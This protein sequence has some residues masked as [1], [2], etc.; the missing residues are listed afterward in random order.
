MATVRVF[1][2]ARTLG[3]Q[4]QAL[5]EALEQMGAGTVT[6]ASAIDEQTAQTVVDLL[7]E[8]AK[9]ARV[10]RE[11]AEAAKEVEAAKQPEAAKVEEGEAAE[12]GAAEAEKEAAEDVEA[13]QRRLRQ[14]RMEPVE[15]VSQL[16]RHIRELELVEASQRLAPEQLGMG[17]EAR[18][19][20][21][22]RPV[23]AV[24]AA[25]VVTVLGHVDHGKTT[26]LD[27]IRNTQVAAGESGGIT[28]H[29][30]ASEVEHQGRRIVFI[31]TPGHAAFT[32][33]RA[34]GAQVTDIAVLVVAATEG[35]RP[36]TIEAV[37]HA[38]AAGVPILVAVN[39]IDLPGADPLRTRQQ[40]LEHGLVP[41]EWG[42]KEIFVDLSAL[43]GEGL[44][45]LLD[46]ILLVAEVEELWVDPQAEFMGVVI[47]SSMDPAQG[48]Q[49]T[50]LV[51][52][53][54]LKV[55]DVVVVG[56]AHGRVRRLRDWRGRS[57]K[58]ME[59]GRP[60]VIVGLSETAEAGEIVRAAASPKEARQA[61]EEYREQR[62]ARGLRGEAEV[63]L[64]ELYRGLHLGETK[65][66]N[67]VVKA[68]VS[69]TAQALASSL[70]RLSDQLEGVDIN[71]VAI[72][73]GEVTESDVMLAVA[74]QAIVIGYNVGA[75]DRVR[76]LVQSEHVELRL[77][78]IIYEI[79]EDIQ[80]A[81]VGL[82]E[83]VYEEQLIG[84]AQVL[85]LFRIS[86]W[87]V[88][89][90]SRITDGRMERGA[91]IEVLRRG[92]KVYDGKISALRHFKDEVAKLE[93][94]TEGGILVSDFR[95][96]EEGDLVQ[97]YGQVEVERR[98]PVAEAG[99]GRG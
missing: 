44:D 58:Q 87:G 13:A 92:E 88:I 15:G 41:E 7:A 61:A 65:V 37:N 47:E 8:Q 96:W 11:Q 86:R 95:G 14:R 6:P 56:G 53:G 21:G 50:I 31:D 30:G 67:L 22:P 10:E 99:G 9:H 46:T 83:P 76:R 26:L 69:G 2:L 85:Q 63:Q 1:A 19:Q 35:V 94:P 42:G 20:R 40:L 4:S 78:K 91:R 34:R 32:A 29:I 27:R 3:L 75:E 62:R 64:Q 25:P 59:A 70:Q 93:A 18:R 52:Q 73:I 72:G 49:A 81:A 98:Q 48:A 36:Q 84:K 97:A 71:V 77:Y 79:L 89:A 39:K 38:R 60:V 82:L 16:E 55:G 57:V 33:M 66:L 28:Q 51:R 54:T 68:D 17:Q 5:I 45:H 90:G 43:T 23:T 12:E 80:K 74:A 24:V